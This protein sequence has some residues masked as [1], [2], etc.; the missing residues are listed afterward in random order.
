MPDEREQPPEYTRYRARRRVLGRGREPAEL[1]A[2]APGAPSRD[3]KPREPGAPPGW[4][5]WATRK[6]II[7]GVLGLIAGW[8][9]LAVGV[10]EESCQSRR[11]W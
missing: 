6:R 8:L 11:F 2:L 4:R 1:G 10:G 3:G 7:L 5:R 9:Q